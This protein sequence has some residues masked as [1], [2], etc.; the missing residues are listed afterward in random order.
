MTMW[1]MQTTY[2]KRPEARGKALMSL[3]MLGSI[4][5]ILKEKYVWKIMIPVSRIIVKTT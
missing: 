1:K 4:W 5:M 3:L 2:R